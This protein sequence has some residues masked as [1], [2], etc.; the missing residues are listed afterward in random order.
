M[1]FNEKVEFLKG[2]RVADINIGTYMQQLEDLRQTMLPSGIHISDLPKRPNYD[3]KMADYA[4]EFWE[5]N[6]RIQRAQQ[7]KLTVI[8]VINQIAETDPDGHRMLTE[9]YINGKRKCQCEDILNVS[10]STRIRI[11]KR[12]IEGL[13]I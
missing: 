4:G 12:A 2:Y 8:A 7:R 1:T 9:V 11:Y 5:I 10:K 13:D 6:E 3:D